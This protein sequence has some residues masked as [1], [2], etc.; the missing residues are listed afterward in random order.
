M[1]QPKLLLHTYFRSSCSA[2][3]RTAAHLK[4]IPLEYSYIHLLSSQQ[5]SPSYT[6][7]NPSASVP[8]LSFTTSSGEAVIIRQS[9][10]I[11][12][13]LEEYF[14]DTPRLLPPPDNIIGRARVRELVNII[15]ND[16]QPPSNLRILRKVESLGG[17]AS[18]AEW[19]KEFMGK[20]LEAYDRVAE[21]NAG[22][23]S[24][25]DEV[26]MADVCLAPA[27]EGALRYGVDVEGLG[28][29]WRV[30]NEIKRLEAFK[31]G[32]WRHQDDTPEEFR[33][34]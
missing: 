34:E 30:Y 3:V 9:I 15:A 14:P 1:S 33:G 22:R 20:G 4:G 12:E 17:E 8:T 6:T 11:L 7:L 28:T 25:G 5:S 23:Y 26:T 24:V 21:G 32:D 10:A 18:P 31:K 13:F 19:A 2:R 16:T 29:V 27:V